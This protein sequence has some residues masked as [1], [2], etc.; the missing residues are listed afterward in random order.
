MRRVYTAA[1]LRF[2]SK[3]IRGT[4]YA[5]ITRLFN[6]RFG[7]SKSVEAVKTLLNRNGL[8]NGF[9]HG[10]PN[11]RKYT[12]RHIQFLKD[13]AA[14]RGNAC[15]TELFN[16]KFGLS[17]TED[18]IVNVKHRHGLYSGVNLGRFQKGNVPHNKGRKGCAPGC[19]KGWFKPGRMPHNY[20]PVGSERID[21]AGYMRVKIRDPKT[22]RAKHVVIWEKANGP[23]PKGCAIIFGDRNKRNFRLK[24]LILVSRAELCVMNRC[25]L[26][27]DNA[28]FTRS[29]KLIADVKMTIAALKKKARKGEG[30][31]IGTV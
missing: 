10:K 23:V 9:G 4:S 13:H 14:W 24:N 5:E 27:Y 19:E 2:L 16:K 28:E 1:H 17:V 20:C 3:R 6:E 11:I 30:G 22:W 29:G 26:V 15:L 8:V 18:A 12:K 21:S 31:Q 7:L 25:G